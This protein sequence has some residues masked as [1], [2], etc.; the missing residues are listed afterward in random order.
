MT[1]LARATRGP[2]GRVGTEPAGRASLNDV[3]AVLWPPP[4]TTSL[5]RRPARAGEQEFIVLPFSRRP[6]LLVPSGR[7][8]S[9]AAVRR[10]GEPG[11]FKAW[12][13]SR[14]LALAL[15][16]G[17]AAVGLGGR[18]RVSASPGADSIEG[19]LSTALGRDV[20]ISTHLGA[21]RA[22]RKPVLQL[23]TARGEAVGFAKISIN[24]L[25][26]N[27]V[28]AERAA[29]EMLAAENLQRLTVPR[30]LHYG[31]WQDHE[32]LVLSALPVWRRRKALRPGQLVAAMDEL[33]RVGGRSRSRLADSS[34]LSSLHSRME[35]IPAG[36]DQAALAA[37]AATLLTAAADAELEFGAWHGDW[38]GWNMAAT[39]DG[40]LVWDW[41]RFTRPA[42]VGFD[43]LHYALQSAVIRRQRPPQAAAAECVATAATALAPFGTTAATAPVVALLYLAD[44]SV[45]YLA[46]RQA[47]AGARLGRPR[48]WLIP[49]IEEAVKQL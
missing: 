2:G 5:A 3:C 27:L 8:A 44:L 43:A 42:P 46:D 33:A 32:I 17:A 47:E 21:A 31:A 1:A 40:L 39:A 48:T 18:L 41:E 12:A 25:T 24:P 28:R 23:L 26:R 6:R 19:Y 38:T 36:P 29:L 14:S 34:F 10:Y 37:A 7:R 22:N 13:G 16:G 35:Q 9:A 30:V 49:A 20:L 4:T 45:R 11:S 15:A